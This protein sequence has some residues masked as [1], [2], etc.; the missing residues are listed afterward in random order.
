MSA[1][2]TYPRRLSS[3]L[4]SKTDIDALVTVALQWTEDGHVDAMPEPARTVLR[5]TQ[6]NASSVGQQL[7]QANADAVYFGG[8]PEGC[9]PD[10]REEAQAE[11]DRDGGTRTSRRTRSTR[12]QG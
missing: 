10:L 11:P 5:L 4:V 3:Q 12:C 8:P 9:D 2:S 6:E 1:G 7:W